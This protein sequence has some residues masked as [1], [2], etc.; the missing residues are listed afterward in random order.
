MDLW[1]SQF[2]RFANNSWY[3]TITTIDNNINRAAIRDF[4][5]NAR[6]AAESVNLVGIEL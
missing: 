4:K 5:S 2:E 6:F 3:A 1:I